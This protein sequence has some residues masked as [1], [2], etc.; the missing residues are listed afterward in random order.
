MLYQRNIKT[1]IADEL[2]KKN[3]SFEE[4]SKKTGWSE[5]EIWLYIDMVYRK[6]YPEQCRDNMQYYYWGETKQKTR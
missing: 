1:T 2:L 6:K 4:I 3:S 5:H